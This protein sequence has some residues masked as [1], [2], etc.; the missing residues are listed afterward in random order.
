MRTGDAGR[1][2]KTSKKSGILANFGGAKN[3]PNGIGCVLFFSS[4]FLFL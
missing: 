2:W 1:K 3:V 4:V